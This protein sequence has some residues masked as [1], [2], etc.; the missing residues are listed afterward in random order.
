MEN[1]RLRR[2]DDPSNTVDTLLTLPLSDFPNAKTATSANATNQEISSNETENQGCY[3]GDGLI[4]ISLPP[5][6]SANGGLTINDLIQGKSV[7]ILG[8]TSENDIPNAASLPAVAAAED[9]EMG[10]GGSIEPVAARLIVEGAT[11]KTM[12]LTR[13][14]TSNSYIVVP[15]MMS[16]KNKSST[17]NTMNDGDDESSNNKRQKLLDSSTFR[18]N[19]EG[20]EL[21]TMP[22]RSIGVIPGEDSPDSTFFLDPCHLTPGH[23][24]GKLRGTLSRWMYDPFDPPQESGEEEGEGGGDAKMWFGYTIAE[25]AHVCRTSQSEIDYAIHNRVLGAEDALAIPSS[26]DDTTSLSCTRYGMLSE[27]GRQTVAM[28]IVTTLLESDM[29]LVWKFGTTSS[30]KEGIQLSSL[31]EE[32]RTNWHRLEGE[33]SGTSHQSKQPQVVTNPYAKPPPHL[34]DSHEESQEE[35]QS[36]FGTPSQFPATQTNNMQLAD[37]VIWHCLRPIVHYNNSTNSSKKDGM[38]ERVQLLPDEVAKLAAHHVFLRGTPKSSSATLQM[39]AGSAATWDEEELLDEWSMRLPSMSSKYEPRLEL[40]WG[41]AISRTKEVGGDAQGA[42]KV[43]QW[44]YFPEA[45]LPLVPSLRIKSMF[46]MRDVWSLEEAAPYLAKFIVL[47]GEGEGDDGKG[48]QS[49][50]AD[51]LGKYAKA[52]TE[53]GGNNSSVTKYMAMPN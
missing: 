31:M 53:K 50:V 26:K 6:N 32:V 38:P 12:E 45:G 3:D 15:P 28:A 11:G 22:A 23:F 13:V 40:L 1:H 16:Q 36:Q 21:I 2:L 14:E 9:G 49:M 27:E 4:L 34:T 44:Q 46:A 48:M 41:V 43:C 30:S 52:V 17:M 29:E 47:G 10:V 39:G 33:G 25:L 35:S 7:Y 8:D 20:R 37:E 18:N 19:K 24:G 5:S 51:L 42:I